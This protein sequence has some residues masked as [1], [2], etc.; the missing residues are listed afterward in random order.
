M[1]N[2]TNFGGNINNCGNANQI[3]SGGNSNPLNIL[4]SKFNNPNA[5]VFQQQMTQ[6]Q[7]QQNNNQDFNMY[8]PRK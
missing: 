4:T 5:N 7:N 2:N 3:F 8:K 6:A 1:T